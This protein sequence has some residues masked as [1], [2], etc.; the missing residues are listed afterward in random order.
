VEGR[1]RCP[2]CDQVTDERLCPRDKVAT[3]L[4]DAPGIDVASVFVGQVIAERYV[5]ERKIGKGGFGAVFAAR[6]TGTGQEIALKCLNTAAGVEDVTLRRFFQEARVTS[7]LRHPNTIR[8]FDFGQ[9]D[10][11]LLYI[12]MELLSGK[13]LKEELS[14]RRKEKRVFTEEEAINVGI[15]VLRS[16]AEAHSVDLVHRDLKPDNIFLHEVPGEEPVIK[17]LDFGIVKLGD[18]TITLGSDSGVPGTPAFMSP[19][20]VTRQQV[21]GRSDLYSLGC[22]LYQLVS[23]KVPLRGDSAMQ[24]LYMHVHEQAADLREKAKTPLSDRFAGVVHRALEK[25]PGDRYADA[26]TMRIALEKCLPG[27]SRAAGVE[28]DPTRLVR[29]P[30]LF[31]GLTPDLDESDA[32]VPDISRQHLPRPNA[33]SRRLPLVLGALFVAMLGFALA[34]LLQLDDPLPPEPDAVRIEPEAAVVEDAP[35]PAPEPAA[36]DPEPQPAPEPKAKPEPPPRPARPKVKPKRIKK[37][38]P[39]EPPRDEILD[40]KI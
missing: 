37:E 33:P 25:D 26:K 2:I 8:V 17:V 32:S 3:L 18:S 27:S 30:S 16:L 6:H 21:D 38:K 7:G 5:I 20:Q 1:R 9:D 4:V 31:N 19:E 22:V 10:T 13:T 34:T 39:P 28:R 29:Q 15:G 24:T 36:I 14:V 11:G 23:G 12:A 40:E 35:A